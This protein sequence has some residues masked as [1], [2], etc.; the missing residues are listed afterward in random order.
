MQ[1]PQMLLQEL[2]HQCKKLHH[3]PCMHAEHTAG[4]AH[5][6][7]Q[8]TLSLKQERRQHTTKIPLRTHEELKTV[9]NNLGLVASEALYLMEC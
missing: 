8:E 1:V 7:M 5:E 6:R 3:H 9:E 4:P 2:Q